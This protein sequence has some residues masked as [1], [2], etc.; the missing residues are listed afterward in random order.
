MISNHPNQYIYFNEL[1]GGVEKAFGYYE[2]DYYQ[3]SGKVG[4][5][6]IKENV[7]KKYNPK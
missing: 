1:Y 2:L 4:T 3:N 5:D 6:W 7:L